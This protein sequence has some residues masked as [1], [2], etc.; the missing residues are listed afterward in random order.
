[1][2]KK[3]VWV[4]IPVYNEE[5]TIRQVLSK[6]KSYNI[7]IVVV[8]DGGKDN[9]YDVVLKEDVFVLRH[10]INLGK[11]SAMI[12]GCDYAVAHG[13]KK[14]I[15]MD[16]DG[17]HDPIFIPEFIK[18]LDKYDL[19]YG[20]REFSKKMP[21]LSKLGNIIISGVL[22]LL[23][24]TDI[25]DTQSGYRAFNTIIYEKIKWN[26]Q[27]YSVESEM[28]ARASMNKISYTQIPI[29]TIYHENYKG[30]SPFDGIKIVLN[31]LKWR[32]FKI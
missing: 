26:S 16:G 2:N 25:R 8:V 30:T 19:V 10:I 20:S 6:V 5:K 28:I 11:G 23:Y 21:F 9:T 27:R 15:L 24:K 7:N 13:A 12:T 3:D 14:I 32:F 22:K 4:V 29:S 1:M 31:L 17:Q 18:K